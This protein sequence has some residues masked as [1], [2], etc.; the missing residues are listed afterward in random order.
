[1]TGWA[2]AR[3]ER[4]IEERPRIRTIEAP[5]DHRLEQLW[6]EVAQVHPVPSARFGIQ[7]FP[8]SDDPARFATHVSKRP[9]TPDIVFR[10]SGMT[11]NRNRA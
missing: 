8:V 7:W 11:L 3:E 6:L 4:S 2:A 1:M 5:D 9:V 10:V